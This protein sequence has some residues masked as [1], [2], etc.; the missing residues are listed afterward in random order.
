MSAVKQFYRLTNQ[1]IELLEKSQ[2]D[3]DQKIAQTESLLDQRETVMKGIFPP[4]TSEEAELGKEL[5]Q[6][7]A[8]LTRLL[9][10]DK[11]LI[12]KEIKGLQAKKESNAKYI[13]PYQNLSTDGMF[14]DKRK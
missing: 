13:N 8:R 5:I 10:A 1:L 3:R 9:E 7:D 14:Y 2:T 6:L 12:Q 11:D 4:Y